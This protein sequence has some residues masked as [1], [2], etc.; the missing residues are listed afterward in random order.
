MKAIK[1]RYF[2]RNH[3]GL[4]GGIE[5]MVVVRF[6]LMERDIEPIQA[7]SKGCSQWAH[8]CSSGAQAFEESCW[9]FN[10]GDFLSIREDKDLN[11]Y[12]NHEGIQKIEVIGEYS[13]EQHVP[14][15]KILIEDLELNRLGGHGV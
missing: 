10:I 2:M 15:D 6:E 14:F 5:H 3:Q 7:L 11:F 12:L 13:P 9:D 1:T 8:N 4:G